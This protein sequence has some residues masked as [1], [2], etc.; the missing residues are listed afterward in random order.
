MA[1]HLPVGATDLTPDDVAD[2]GE[3]HLVLWNTTAYFALRPEEA[4]GRVQ[5]DHHDGERLVGSFVGGRVDDR[6]RSGHLA[7]FG[8][9]DV[10]RPNETVANVEGLV[11]TALARLADDGVRTVEVLAKPP[12]Y[13]SNEG[14]LEFVL[15]NR[16]FTVAGAE[17]NAYLALDGYGSPDDYAADLKP[18]ARKMLRRSVGQGL[19]AFQVAP[20]DDAGWAEAHEVLRR[21]RADRGRPM[22]LDVG[23]VRSIRDA[24]PGR[25]RL[26][27]LAGEDRM[28]AAALLYR[29]AAGRDVVQYWG[30][31]L[32]ELPV[33]PMNALV[34]TVVEHS[35][36]SG[37][38]T[39]DIGI[40]SE[41]GVPNH[42]LI[43]FKRSVGCRLEPR[44]TFRRDDLAA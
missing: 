7:P 34:R 44:L 37:T 14:V 17:I 3:A 38:R 2:P 41:D 12:H 19:T 23:Y 33:S 22:H 36:A 42:G 20:G 43:Q 32:H 10:A 1:E 18:A 13:G 25:V 35:L 8:G 16:G 39:L 21:N 27:A 29:V 40:S 6:C 5:I 24:F 15:L 9:L 11:D 31:A 30:D 26:L 4:P 28:V